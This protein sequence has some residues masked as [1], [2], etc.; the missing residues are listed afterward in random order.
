MLWSCSS[1]E[2]LSASNSR[3]STIFCGTG[4]SAGERISPLPKDDCG[5]WYVDGALSWFWVTTGPKIT[6]LVVVWPQGLLGG[7]D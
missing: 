3:I 1:R 4:A 2:M 5:N 6:T 7:L